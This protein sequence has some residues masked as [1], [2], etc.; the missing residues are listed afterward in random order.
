MATK[1]TRP[2]AKTASPTRD[3]ADVKRADNDTPDADEQTYVVG[4]DGKRVK[5]EDYA[6]SD[7]FRGIVKDA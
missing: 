4:H 1:R 2:T 7:E 3:T 5:S 6:K